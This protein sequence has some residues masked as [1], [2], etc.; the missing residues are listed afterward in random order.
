[1]KNRKLVLILVAV[2]V[3]ALVL[4]SAIGGKGGKTITVGAKDFTEQYILGSMISI[5]LN[6]NGFEVTERFGT[7]STITREGL[8]TNQT[9]LYPEYTGTAWAVYLNHA[10]EVISDPIALYNRVKAD[11]DA[12]GIVWLKPAPLNNTYA[13]AIKEENVAKYGD[14]LKSLA[15]YN[16]AHPGELI[17]GIDHEF[18]ERADGFWAMAEAYGMKVDKNQVKTMDIGLSFESIDRGQI[19]VAMVFATDGKLQKFNLKVLS[20]PQNFFPLYNMAV[21]VRQEVLEE[22]PEIEEILAPL[23]ELDDE[24]MQMLNYKVDA[25]EIPPEVVARDYLEEQGLI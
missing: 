9:D 2:A 24:T 13:L 23:S 20:D 21:C 7:G 25:E 19:D 3:L 14:S 17:Y 12:N 11:D 4:W 1:M 15:A 8:E 10:D 5:L 18:Y 6:E 16:N 22:Y